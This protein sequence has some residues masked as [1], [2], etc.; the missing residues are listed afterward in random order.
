M[1]SR[2]NEKV[3]MQLAKGNGS[4]MH[5]HCQSA[6]RKRKICWRMQGVRMNC[7]QGYAPHDQ[8]PEPRI[9]SYH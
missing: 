5:E 7:L 9:A 2:E 8:W 6:L 3:R 1:R 4:C